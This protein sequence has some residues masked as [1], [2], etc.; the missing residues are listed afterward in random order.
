MEQLLT[1]VWMKVFFSVYEM[2]M[3]WVQKFLFVK[4]FNFFCP[5]YWFK[6]ELN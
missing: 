2:T 1:V 4:I 5:E 6:T 3:K